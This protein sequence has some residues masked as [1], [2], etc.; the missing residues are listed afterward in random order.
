L[1]VVAR[2]LI[3]GPDSVPEVVM[4]GEHSSLGIDATCSTVG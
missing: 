4:S 3:L 1:P 2:E